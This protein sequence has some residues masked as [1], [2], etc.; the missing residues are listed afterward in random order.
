MATVYTEVEVDVELSDFDDED[1]IEEYDR[2]DLENRQ[3]SDDDVISKL[4]YAYTQ[5][6]KDQVEL[7]MRDLFYEKL[8]R[9]V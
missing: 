4:H 7:L 6:Q 5:G 8:G 9:I 2:R 1:I 3:R